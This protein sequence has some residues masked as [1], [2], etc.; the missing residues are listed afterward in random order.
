M[1]SAE[2]Q[3]VVD[4]F[5]SNAAEAAIPVPI[6]G[7][8]VSALIDMILPSLWPSAKIDPMAEA[9]AEVKQS[10][11]NPL[12]TLAGIIHTDFNQL[13]LEVQAIADFQMN[14]ASDA[15]AASNAGLQDLLL[16]YRQNFA[17]ALQSGDNSKLVGQLNVVTTSVFDV[18]S[19]SWLDCYQC[20]GIYVLGATVALHMMG[21]LLT[22]DTF[23]GTDVNGNP[24]NGAS[25]SYWY[26]Q[27][28]VALED[29][30]Q[31]LQKVRD[32][33][34]LAIFNQLTSSQSVAGILS[35]YYDQKGQIPPISPESL[36]NAILQGSSGIGPIGKLTN[37]A[38][39]ISQDT[40]REI[41]A[42]VAADAA[43]ANWQTTSN[44]IGAL[45]T[46]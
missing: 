1:P 44:S 45:T 42:L 15:P 19:P 46:K 35:S 40:R 32:L 27:L 23:Y 25:G 18:P 6:V 24:V 16:T 29:N 10:L 17:V 31:E 13:N 34:L 21:Q 12:N 7:K 22:Y 14:H 20:L 8:A 38:A 30:L 4:G 39:N 28:A 3:S 2:V 37:W 36:Q 43:I 41:D 26:A 5:I 33:I 11:S 9:L